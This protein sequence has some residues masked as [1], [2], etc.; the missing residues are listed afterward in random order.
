[1]DIVSQGRELGSKP[2]I[3]IA[4]P[5]RLADLLNSGTEFSL[6]KIKFLVLDEA[7]RLLEKS[8]EKDLEVIFENIAEKRQTLLFSATLTD[9][10]NQLQEITSGRPFCHEVTSDT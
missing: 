4:T 5:G 10:I 6:K 9:T 7:D 1:M 8:F 3:V 2:H